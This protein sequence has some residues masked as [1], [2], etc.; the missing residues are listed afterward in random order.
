MNDEAKKRMAE[1]IAATKKAN[2][3][4]SSLSEQ[5]TTFSNPLP[6]D[7]KIEYVEDNVSKDEFKEFKSSVEDTQ[8]KIIDILEKMQNKEAVVEKKVELK[9]DPMA[10]IN[11][12]FLPPAYQ[13]IVNEHFAVEDGFEC[14]LEFPDKDSN[15]G[16]TFT[17]KVP[18]KLSNMIQAQKDFYKLD[19]RT[20]SLQPNSIAKGIDDWCKRVATNLK[21]DRKFKFKQ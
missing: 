20:I 3:S 17:I 9:D 13:S 11:D 2:S 12:K 18:D 4:I 5:S 8:N 16:L 15:G 6:E 10:V 21:Y 1:K 14:K 7:T 19:L